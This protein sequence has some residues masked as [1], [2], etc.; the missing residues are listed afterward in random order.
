M[1]TQ[2]LQSKLNQAWQSVSAEQLRAALLLVLAV[3]FLSLLADIFWRVMPDPAEGVDGNLLLLLTPQ[4]SSQKAKEPS[5]VDIEKMQS[6]HLFGQADK[7]EEVAES[8]EQEKI[9]SDDEALEAKETQ[10]R[11]K[12]LGLMRSNIDAASYAVIEA[13]NTA[14]LYVVG[15]ALPVGQNVKLSR[16]LD[17]RVIIDNRGNLEALLLYDENERSSSQRNVTVQQNTADA[18]DERTI[19]QR[20]NRRIT[21][22]AN[23]Y[24]QRLMSNPMSLADVISISMARDNNGN[25]LGYSVRP[26][27][28]RRQFTELGL[29][30]GDIVTAVNGISLQD[31]SGAMEIYNHLGSA[32]EASL[33]IK[34]GDEDIVILVGL[35]E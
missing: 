12:L 19:D 15:Q 20:N 25:V 35:S 7:L 4:T 5:Y 11:L 29:R 26:G 13:N 3:A 32:K 28:D 23:S 9:A 27:R 10:L 18:G 2:Q 16:V 21:S 8:G 34:R 6:W 17:D 33:S 1:V 24:R 30:S 14:D 22:M 31:P